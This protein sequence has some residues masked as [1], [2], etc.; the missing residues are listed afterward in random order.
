MSSISAHVRLRPIRFAFL[1]RPDDLSRTIEIFR[2]NTC[3]W[4]GKFNPI[5]PYFTEVQAGAI[6]AI[7]RNAL[8]VLLT[9][10]RKRLADPKFCG[11]PA[12]QR[13]VRS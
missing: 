5:I 9:G 2:V 13:S 10:R 4:G 12:G 11:P 7:R 1:V 6:G 8:L 3:L